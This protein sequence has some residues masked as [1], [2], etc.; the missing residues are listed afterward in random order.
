[1]NKKLKYGT[2]AAV[3]TAAVTSPFFLAKEY[4][5]FSVAT[6]LEEKIAK[7]EGKDG[8]ENYLLHLRLQDTNR[9]CTLYVAPHADMPIAALNEV[10]TQG[11]TVVL[12]YLES[13]LFWREPKPIYDVS[14]FG[15]INSNHL[16][17]VDHFA[18]SDVV[19]AQ[20]R[21]TIQL[22]KEKELRQARR[23]MEMYHH[24]KKL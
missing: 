15:K 20:L 22:E 4:D 2:I 9:L 3:V 19:K 7:E 24:R 17:V 12:P 14:C 6:V 5:T 23:E 1:M 13:K 16:K 21:E 8:K 11:S 10:I 18:T